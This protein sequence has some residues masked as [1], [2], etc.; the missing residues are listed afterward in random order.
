[1]LQ[2]EH[3]SHAPRRKRPSCPHTWRAS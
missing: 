3:A 1:M 2:K